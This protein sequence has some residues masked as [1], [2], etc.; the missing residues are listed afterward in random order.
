[1][2]AFRHLILRRLAQLFGLQVLFFSA[3]LFGALVWREATITV[4]AA[5]LA[6]AGGAATALVGVA[7]VS[8]TNEIGVRFW[9]QFLEHQVNFEPLPQPIEPTTP[10]R[11]FERMRLLPAAVVSDPLRRRSTIYHILQTRDRRAIVSVG[12]QSGEISLMTTL[13]SGR[14]LVTSAILLPPHPELVPNMVP[15]AG[16]DELMSAHERLR[17]QLAERGVT[18]THTVPRVFERVAQLEQE[19]VAQLTPLLASLVDWSY[20]AGR[21]RIMARID[22]DRLRAIALT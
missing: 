17:A 1:M 12:H 9:R 16:P 4:S 11:Q 7:A 20:T 21:R 14:V 19:A 22:P 3:L 13:S 10:V 6:L 2:G 18:A 8:W 5:V 15:G